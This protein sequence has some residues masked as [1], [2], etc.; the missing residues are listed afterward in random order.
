MKRLLNNVA[1]LSIGLALVAMMADVAAAQ[2]G[3]G[4]GRGGFGGG[5]R[6]GRG[7][8]GGFG[9]NQAISKIQLAGV[10]QVQTELKL[11]D[12]EKQKVRDHRA[13][14]GRAK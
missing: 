13:L 2:P 1:V 12:E 11:T 8:R 14:P 5:G 10:E 7:G 4:G 3:Q 6:G 9:A